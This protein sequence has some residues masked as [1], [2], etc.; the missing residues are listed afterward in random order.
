MAECFMSSIPTVEVQTFFNPANVP[1]DTQDIH[2]GFRSSGGQQVNWHTKADVTGAAA[3]DSEDDQRC[4]WIHA[5]PEDDQRG[6]ANA[7]QH[8]PHLHT[9][10]PLSP[11]A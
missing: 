10:T 8:S 4:L 1:C 6:S 11:Q 9:S 3:I 2:S 5:E 7:T